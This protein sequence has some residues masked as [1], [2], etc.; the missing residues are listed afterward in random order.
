MQKTQ[1]KTGDIG[2]KVEE[3]IKE[4]EKLENKKNIEGMKR[5][6]ITS[7]AR[8]LGISKPVLKKIAKKLGKNTFLALKLWETGIHEARILAT[9]IAD[10]KEFEKEY[11]LIWV[12]D[13]DNWDICDQFALNLLW[14]T[15][16]AIEIAKHFCKS[17][18]EFV[19]REGLA[20]MAKL[21]MSR[22]NLDRKVVEEFKEIAE[23]HLSDRRKYVKKAALWVLKKIEK[24]NIF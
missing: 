7:K 6:G 4:L 18:D 1:V 12:K 2:I 11:A 16:Y 22:K 23:K 19:K 24:Q 10:P 14:K 17:K 15:N 5:F 9:L 20:L 3:V 21:L 8:I 13:V